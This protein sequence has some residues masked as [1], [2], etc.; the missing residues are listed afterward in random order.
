M[1]DDNPRVLEALRLPELCRQ[2]CLSAGLPLSPGPATEERFVIRS[3]STPPG[4]LAG[5]LEEAFLEDEAEVLVWL[6]AGP[7]DFRRL[8]PGQVV[9]RPGF[10]G[11]CPAADELARAVGGP[12]LLLA[13]ERRDADGGP[14]AV[15]WA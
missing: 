11:P 10:D 6:A 12:A 1:S 15:T 4:L 8:A 7:P 14:L 5:L 3:G 2:V 9:V 13:V